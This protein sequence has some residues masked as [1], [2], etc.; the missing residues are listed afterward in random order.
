M[1]YFY[2]F[3]FSF[4]LSLCVNWV[5]NVAFHDLGVKYGQRTKI[6]QKRP[7]GQKYKMVISHQK[8]K[9]TFL[10]LLMNYKLEK[11]NSE[12]FWWFWDS[13]EGVW[14]E[15]IC[16]KVI[17]GISLFLAVLNSEGNFG[18]YEKSVHFLEKTIFWEN[19]S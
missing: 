19:Y 14:D 3:I 2:S 18:K 17:F 4:L 9:I 1:H 11:P 13:F 10:E 7:K 12:I 15:K 6:V 8:W 16:K 5:N